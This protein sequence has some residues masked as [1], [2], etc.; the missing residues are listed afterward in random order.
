[1]AKA[2]AMS[3]RRLQQKLQSEQTGYRELLDHVRKETALRL[4]LN[5]D[6]TISEI[7]FILGFSDQSSFTHAFQT[8][9]G[10][11]PGKYRKIAQ[12]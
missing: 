7:T 4:L 1:V 3:P 10:T 9:T 12:L 8:W 6:T 5:P 2:L 11:T